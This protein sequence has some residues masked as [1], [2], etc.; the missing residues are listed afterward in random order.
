MVLPLYLAMTASEISSQPSLPAYMAYMACS[1][2]PYALGLSGIPSSLPGGK[3]LIVNDRMRCQGHSPDLVVGQLQEMVTRHE[4]ESVL[5]DFQRLPEPESDTMVRKITQALSCPVAATEGFAADLDCPVFLSPAPL[6]I[7]L[8]EYL[9]PWQGR[10]IWLEA[11]LGQ[12][13]I[14]VTP[15]GIATAAQ[16]PPDGLSGGFVDET[17]SCRYRTKIDSERI[18]FTLFDT[19][20]DL[21]KKLELAQALGVARAVGLWQELKTFQIGMVPA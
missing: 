3:M 9:A 13:E 19:Q 10:E 1:F 4:C 20:E 21:E 5:L 6:H 2:S 12:E 16:F 8:V 7:P 18:T 11:A 15:K 17:L 14:R